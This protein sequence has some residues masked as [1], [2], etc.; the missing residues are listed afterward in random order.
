MKDFAA[1][2]AGRDDVHGIYRLPRNSSPDEQGKRTGKVQTVEASVTAELYQKHLDGE[3]PIGIVPIRLDGTVSF[4]A[5][6]V[7]SYKDADLHAELISEIDRLALPLV[8][9]RSK[10]NGAH[11]WCFLS[12]P[13]P[14]VQA[15]DVAADFRRKLGLPEATEIFPK[16]D[17]IKSGNKGSW[18]NLPYFGNT[19][20]GLGDDGRTELSL[21]QFIEYANEHVTD[22]DDLKLKKKETAK[23][24]L[25]RVTGKD[26]P[27]PC[28]QAMI[29][30]GVESGMRDKSLLQAAIYYRKTGKDGWEQDV[31]EFNKEHV[32]PSMT[33]GEVAQKIK[34]AGRDYQYMCKEFVTTCDK[35]ACMKLDFGIGTGAGAGIGKF[36]EFNQLE[37]VD[38]EDGHYNVTMF[39]HRFRVTG[40]Q[41][42]NFTLFRS[43]VVTHCGE[44]LQKV[45]T[46]E[47]DKII[48]DALVAK[49][50][51]HAPLETQTSDRV[52]RKWQEWVGQFGVE[53]DLEDA[54]KGGHAFLQGPV[55]QFRISDFVRVAQR[56]FPK[57]TATQLFTALREWGDMMTVVAGR[58]G[59]DELKL[60][61]YV[62]PPDATWLEEVKRKKED[63][64]A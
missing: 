63:K 7:D 16:Q 45:K 64:N 44:L 47:W 4:F 29:R 5:I 62:L 15:R 2:F 8:V 61:E 55:I 54:L 58:R 35:Q 33:M 59:K 52:V 60:T 11:L 42:M 30:D 9:T 1:L 43:A 10:S 56:D 27:P 49:K 12:E 41:L 21:E 19:R 32:K 57:A 14:A 18:I 22:P 25:K 3:L 26:A 20:T 38:G 37:W 46:D 51:T 48:E 17:A 53:T 34:Q 50:V 23:P 28:I 13:I 24:A 40:T 31:Y 39:G 6:D 36:P